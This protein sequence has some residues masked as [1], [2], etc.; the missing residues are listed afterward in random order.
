MD[1]R[2]TDEVV[3]LL[4]M[5]YLSERN[6]AFQMYDTIQ[7]VQRIAQA[8]G[9]HP[10][11]HPTQ[12]QNVIWVLFL[13]RIIRPGIERY[14]FSF[15]EFYITE[16]GKILLSNLG[17]N[18]HDHQGYIAG[19]KTIIP[20]LDPVVEQYLSESL[21]CFR[22]RLF[23]S[24][25]VMLG[26]AAEKALYLLFEAV[27]AAKQDPNEQSK[28]KKLFDGPNIPKI[29]EAI[30][31]TLSPLMAK[32]GTMDYTVHEG[33]TQHLM[34]FQDMIRVQRNNCVHPDAGQFTLNKLSLSLQGF[35][36]ALQVI[37]RLIEWFKQR[38]G[39]I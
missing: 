3:R 6:I 36:H 34:S 1:N 32:G 15:K 13:D 8:K 9:Y 20:E 19:L 12:I 33:A 27:I 14:D 28:L 23:F 31:K 37:Y 25:A 2:P 38:Q 7:N 11:L 22:Q 18:I 21:L 26:A 5:Q 39:G 24:S 16:Y 10:E 30:E 4:V 35:P 29:F 17:A